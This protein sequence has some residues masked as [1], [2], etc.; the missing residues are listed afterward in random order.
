M[1]FQVQ[2][3]RV[4]T[5]YS[6]MR[7]LFKENLCYSIVEGRTLRIPYR[8]EYQALS[9]AKIYVA[10]CN[11]VNHAFRCSSAI[12]ICPLWIKKIAC[13]VVYG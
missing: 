8:T 5:T 12:D 13:F 11:F 1:A 4:D 9:K 10:L 3:V 6:I 2:F 7:A